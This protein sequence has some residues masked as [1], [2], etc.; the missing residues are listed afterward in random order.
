MCVR[1]CVSMHVNVYVYLCLGDVIIII[2][3]C[4]VLRFI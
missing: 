4:I 3:I 2:N 1:A